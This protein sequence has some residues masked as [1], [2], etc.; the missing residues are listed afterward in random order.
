MLSPLLNQVMILKHL[1]SKYLMFWKTVKTCMLFTPYDEFYDFGSFPSVMC[2]RFVFFFWI[3]W[4]VSRL[5]N[6]SVYKLPHG[7]GSGHV[8][9][10]SLGFCGS[11][12]GH[13]L[14]LSFY[15]LSRP[16]YSPLF[17]FHLISFLFGHGHNYWFCLC[18]FP[19]LDF[20]VFSSFLPLVF[21]F[22]VCSCK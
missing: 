15:S 21:R 5:W 6:H 9:C 4:N 19:F 8:K 11:E 12:W 14:S 22:L 3:V 7:P 1:C 17:L 20:P 13:M 10:G 16:R 2:V 18:C